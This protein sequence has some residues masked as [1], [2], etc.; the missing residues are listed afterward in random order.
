VRWGDGGAGLS[1]SFEK[2]VAVGAAARAGEGAVLRGWVGLG[3]MGVVS[4]LVS[5]VVE[6]LGGCFRRHRPLLC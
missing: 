6:A 5:G 2:G 4:G 1:W 3:V